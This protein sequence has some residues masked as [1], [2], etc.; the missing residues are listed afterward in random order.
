MAKRMNEYFYSHF[1][2]I[3]NKLMANLFKDVQDGYENLY[4]F[5]MIES[6][7][8][9]FLFV[10][11]ELKMK[12]MHYFDNEEDLDNLENI[13]GSLIDLFGLELIEMD[14]TYFLNEYSKITEDRIDLYENLF[15]NFNEEMFIRIFHNIIKHEIV[16]KKLS[17]K[18]TKMNIDLNK[19]DIVL[20]E[21]ISSNLN[22]LIN[23]FFRYGVKNYAQWEILSR[24]K[25]NRI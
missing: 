9:E 8:F 1:R 6:E 23:L 5:Q 19:N 4:L 25:N 20:Y 13:L 14:F 17:G 18:K 16:T 15:N 22:I 24:N 3:L 7:V 10:W 2:F 12:K 11:L 21:N